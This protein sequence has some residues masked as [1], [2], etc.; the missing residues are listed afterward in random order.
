MTI[1]DIFDR[2]LDQRPPGRGS[3]PGAHTPLERLPMV[4]L[5]CETTGLDSR[6]DRIVS[7]ALVPI[8]AGLI[9]ASRPALDL[10]IDPQ[11]PIPPAATKIHRLDDAAVAGAPT[12][13]EAWAAIMAA[14]K[15]AVVIGHHVG[16]DIAMLARE[17]RRTGCFWREP[18]HLDTAAMAVG[19]GL[20]HESL[21]L[22]DMLVRLGVKSS[23]ERHTAAGDAAMA[24]ALFVAMAQR[25]RGQGRGTFAGA[26]AAQRLPRQ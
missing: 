13:A 4:A 3:R 16:F 21:D 18:P 5:D 25:L 12:I 19:L 15:D 20:A 26:V 1:A 8:D 24:A 6:R 9:V 2:Y 14:M 17:A 23:E 10:V 7:I 22:A 11:M